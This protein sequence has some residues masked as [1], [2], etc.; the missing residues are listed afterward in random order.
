MP[1]TGVEMVAELH[2]P[3]TGACVVGAVVFGTVVFGWLVGVVA[4]GGAAF[5]ASSVPACCSVCST[6]C[7]TCGGTF[8]PP[9]EAPL[10]PACSNSE[11]HVLRPTMPSTSSPAESWYLRTAASVCGPKMPSDTTPSSLCT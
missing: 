1:L 7:F 10:A 9:R 5:T 3:L 11:D 4:E 6:F 8:E 2:E